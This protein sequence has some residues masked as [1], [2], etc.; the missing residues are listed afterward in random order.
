MS[1]ETTPK[2]ESFLIVAYKPLRGSPGV[3]GRRGFVTE[4]LF[5]ER[6]SK[7]RLKPDPANSLNAQRTQIMIVIPTPDL[8]SIRSSGRG[9]WKNSVLIGDSAAQVRRF[10]LEKDTADVISP[11]PLSESGERGF[12]YLVWH[13]MLIFLSKDVNLIYRQASSSQTAHEYQ[14]AALLDTPGYLHNYLD[15]SS[16]NLQRVCEVLDA[17][18]LLYV[19]NQHQLIV[20]N[21]RRVKSFK[22]VID[23]EAQPLVK[24][25]VNF[26]LNTPNDQPNVPQ[27]VPQVE[28]EAQDGTSEEA[29][30]KIP[31]E[32]VKI[33]P[34]IPIKEHP[35]ILRGHSDVKMDTREI[36][37]ASC[38][39]RV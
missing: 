18:I 13:N 3:S 11:K 4:E 14:L 32:P 39:E 26:L 20:V 36:G 19:N 31:K 28:D 10:H 15:M 9:R 37:R 22:P 25:W 1:A 24:K 30:G 29:A 12:A 17:G 38:R 21:L 23:E 8:N 35:N 34:E 16:P 5:L 27:I 33:T 2:L 6:L 7:Y